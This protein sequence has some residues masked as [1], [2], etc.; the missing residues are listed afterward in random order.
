MKKITFLL[1]SFACLN[2]YAQPSN[3]TPCGVTTFLNVDIDGN[4]SNQIFSFDGTESDSGIGDPSCGLPYSG[5]DLWYK[6]IMPSD[7]S[8]VRIK[9]SANTTIDDLA[10][11]L[12]TGPDCSNLT[13]IDCDDDDN[14][15]PYP[16]DLFPQIDVIESAN[17]TVYFRVW[18]L[19]DFGAGSFNICLYKIDTPLI[20]NNDECSSAQELIPTSDCSSPV[21]TTNFQSTDS[22]VS[23][24]TC[25]PYYSGKDVWYKISLDDNDDYNL[26]IET[27]EDLGSSVYD[28]GIVV[29]SGSCGALNEIACNDDNDTDFFSKVDLTA[30]RNETL[31]IRVFMVDG[32]QSGTFNIC[33]TKT[34]TL[35]VNDLAIDNYKLYPN[36]ATNIV[37]LKFN[38]SL[39]NEIE[40]NVFSIQGKLVINT[41]KQLQNKSSQLDISSLKSG[42]YFL[43]ISDGEHT[44]TKKLIIK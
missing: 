28:T 26:S 1:F 44:S 9:A 17:T 38:Q 13:S 11:E 33:A 34:V 24:P 25:T 14:P 5:K 4:C 35:G 42:L 22:S 40:I 32:P 15:D 6:F 3:N 16:D 31:F 37:N 18:D 41:T 23:D 43:K 36:P 8:A 21:L 7:G 2:L 39:D 20:A 30:R 19:D 29:Y 10:I 12:F 27:S